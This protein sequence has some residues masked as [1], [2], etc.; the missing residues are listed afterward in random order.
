[1]KKPLLIFATQGEAAP[2]RTARS[3][4]DIR[5]CGVGL[6]ETAVSVAEIIAQQRPS[7]VVL[8]GIAGAYNKSLAIG[9]VVCVSEERT[10]SLPALYRKSYSATLA[11]PLKAVVSNSVMSVGEAADG[12]EIENM[13]GAAV[14]ALCHRYGIPC[15]EIRA[16]SNYVSDSR[17]QWDIPTALKA[18]AVAIKSILQ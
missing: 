11:L 9:E 15:A 10:H 18:L 16:I 14:F 7:Q 5:I 13:E 8:C 4:L 2:I 1:M 6:V 3:D 12:A 17:E